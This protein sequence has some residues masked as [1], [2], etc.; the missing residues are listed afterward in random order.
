MFECPKY[1]WLVIINM[2]SKFWLVSLIFWSYSWKIITV[3]YNL[4]YSAILINDFLKEL[5]LIALRNPLFIMIH[6]G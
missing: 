4:Y 3:P 1:I 2:R 6:N 5:S